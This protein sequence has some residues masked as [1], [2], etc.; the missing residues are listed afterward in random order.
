MAIH[1]GAIGRALSPMS[2]SGSVEIDGV[3]HDARS[4]GQFIDA[5]SAVIVLRGDP[6]GYVVRKLEPGQPVPQLPNHGEPIFKAEFQRNSAEVAEAERQERL[7]R[8]RQQRQA[9]KYG[10]VAAG[11]LG[12]LVGLSSG[13]LGWYFRWAGVTEPVYLALLLGG[14]L[15]LGAVWGVV[16]FLSISWGGA[17]LGSLEGDVAFAP[18]FV[19]VFVALVGAAVGFWWHFS[20]GD[21]GTI[22]LWSVGGTVVFAAAALVLGWLIGTL[23]E[24]LLGGG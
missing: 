16:L 8:H 6:T 2:P 3:R 19:V 5:G 15:V 4:D 24:A 11:S 20:T 9:L 17:L 10:V 13:G 23:A 7:E 22:A 12:A 18:S 14:S 1:V 21:V